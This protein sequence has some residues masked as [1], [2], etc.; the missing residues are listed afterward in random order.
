MKRLFGHDSPFWRFQLADRTQQP[1]LKLDLQLRLDLFRISTGSKASSH[2]KPILLRKLQEIARAINHWFGVEWKPERRSAFHPV[3]VKSGRRYADNGKW[4][5][6]ENEGRSHHR[7]SFAVLF[8][9]RSITHHRHRLCSRSIVG[10]RKHS[11]GVGPN[12][13][14]GEVVS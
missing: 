8:L 11:P 5:P 9:P 4:V 2:I 7:L 1:L 13:K 6:I 10:L 3:A 14:H 12:A